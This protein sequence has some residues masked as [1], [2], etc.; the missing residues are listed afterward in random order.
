MLERTLDAKYREE[1]ENHP[2]VPPDP[3]VYEFAEE[4]SNHNIIF[5]ENQES[6]YGVL[7]KVNPVGLVVHCQ[8]NCKTC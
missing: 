1:E 6:S 8:M 4:D 5:E 3:E 2:L 7:I